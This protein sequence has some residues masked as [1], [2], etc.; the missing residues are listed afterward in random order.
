[1]SHT[2]SGEQTRAF[3]FFTDAQGHGVVCARAGCGKTTTIVE[4]V[5]R[6]LRAFPGRKVVVCA[7]NKKIADEL[8]LRFT[9]FPVEV[10]TLH[11]IGRKFV[12]RNWRGVAIEDKDDAGLRRDTL[13]TQALRGRVQGDV[14]PEIHKL[15]GQ[16]HCLGREILP[17]AFRGSELADLAFEFDCVP[18]EQHAEAGWTLDVVCDLAA[19]AMRIA[20]AEQPVSTGIDFADMIFL[21]IR[22]RWIRGWWDLVV[23][24]EYQ[25]MNRT[26][27]MIA[28]GICRRGTG[29]LVVVGD[30][31]QAIYG[32]RGADV[33]AIDRIKTELRATEMGLKTTYRCGKAIVRMAARLVPDFEAGPNNPEGEIVFLGEDQLV[34]EIALGDM[35]LS[36]TT[37]PLIPTAMQLLRAGKRTR[38]AGRKIGDN[39]Q[40]LVQRLAKSGRTVPGFLERLAGWQKRQTARAEKS[41]R[42]PEAA[43]R[44]VEAIVDQADMLRGLAEGV[45]STD[46]IVNRIATLFSD[47]GLGDAGVITCSSVHRAKGLEANRVFL[48]A[49]T[50]RDNSDEELNI[51]YVAI[52]R[53]KQ[54]LT[55]V[56]AAKAWYLTPPAYDERVA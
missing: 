51:G 44:K 46:E 6:Y 28:L 38:I 25:D 13:T 42:T 41:A 43:G 33:N 22:N 52:T 32:W 2:W 10:Y 18:D 11:A 12:M 53:A 23:V 24:D 7:F 48:L 39:L 37:A 9:G 15:I 31:R 1:M 30:P 14:P 29:R 34:G 27:Q 21:P 47:N 49:E 8:I 17:L 19:E 4:A 45:R 16:L 35:F 20:A 26:Q 36:R 3:S 54:T 56:G 5:M 50:F 40:A 55:M